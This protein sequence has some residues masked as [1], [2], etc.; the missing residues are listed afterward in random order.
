MR[1]LWGKKSNVAPAYLDHEDFADQ[2]D[3]LEVNEDS[4]YNDDDRIIPITPDEEVAIMSFNKY[5]PGTKMVLR[6]I[7]KAR[8]KSLRK[9][10]E[11]IDAGVYFPRSTSCDFDPGQRYLY[12]EYR[13]SIDEGL[14]WLQ[15]KLDK[16]NEKRFAMEYKWLEVRHVP[17]LG[18][19]SSSIQDEDPS[20]SEYCRHPSELIAAIKRF[21]EHAKDVREI[22][23][24]TEPKSNAH[25]HL[26]VDSDLTLPNGMPST[27]TNFITFH[28]HRAEQLAAKYNA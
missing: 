1:K 14:H 16:L 28:Q 10:Q 25:L 18:E 15:P 7:I 5:Y 23:R 4:E 21:E 27:M 12:H 17:H 11:M 13:R 26:G 6:P 22:Y 8:L 19:A 24:W 3:R 20:R 9:A 2:L